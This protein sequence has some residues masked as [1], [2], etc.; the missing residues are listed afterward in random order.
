MR[1]VHSDICIHIHVID[2][3]MI[4][5]NDEL[6]Q[7]TGVKC[8]LTS[9]YHPQSNGLDERCNQT[10]QRQLLKFV[11]SEQT[12]WDLHLDAMLFFYWV[13]WQDS[14]KYSPFCLVYGHQPRLLI[15]I[16][17]KLNEDCCEVKEISVVK[18]KKVYCKLVL[19]ELCLLM[20]GRGRTHRKQSDLKLGVSL[21]FNNRHPP[22]PPPFPQRTM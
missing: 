3:N 4:K 7:L 9:A 17:T 10:L 2:V 11:D 6:C 15:E 13:S 16:N 12:D 8:N 22:P 21:A 14:T 5:V 19:M 20:Y 18:Q 1:F